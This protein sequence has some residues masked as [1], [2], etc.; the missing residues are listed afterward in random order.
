MKDLAVRLLF[1]L[2]RLIDLPVRVRPCVA[3]I[4]SVRIGT[5]AVAS[6]VGGIRDMVRDAETGFL[7]VPVNPLDSEERPV[8]ILDYPL[9]LTGVSHALKRLYESHYSLR[10]LRTRQIELYEQ[11]GE[12]NK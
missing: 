10:A 3:I 5:P 9:D 1:A 7:F 6:K 12:G 11:L 4:E 2:K 8:Q